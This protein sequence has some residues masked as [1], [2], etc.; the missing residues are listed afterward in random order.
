[1]T[2]QFDAGR[3]TT[4][5]LAELGVGTFDLDA[6]FVTH[7]HS[8]HLVGLPDVAMT[9]WIQGALHPSGP[10]VVVAP[11]GHAARF[12]RRMLDPYVDD[13]AVRMEHVQPD[14]PAVDVV[15]FT[16]PR[17]RPRCGGPAK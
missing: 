5:R 3:G 14:P 15:P 1:V 4:M 13:I 12:A 10:L 16:P 8:D 6:V 2:L 7:V 17:H 9:R 11:E